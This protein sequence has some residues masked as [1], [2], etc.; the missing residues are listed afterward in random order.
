MTNLIFVAFTVACLIDFTYGQNC[1][2][3]QKAFYASKNMDRARTRY[4]DE[5]N[6]PDYDLYVTEDHPGFEVWAEGDVAYPFWDDFS[7]ARVLLT[8]T[9]IINHKMFFKREC[10]DLSAYTKCFHRSDVC[11]D[12]FCLCNECNAKSKY[13]TMGGTCNNI[14]NPKLGAQYSAYGRILPPDYH[15][16]IHSERRSAISSEELPSPRIISNILSQYISGAE[17]PDNQTSVLNVFGSIF[18]QLITHDVGSRIN[19]QRSVPFCF[20]QKYLRR[21]FEVNEG[22]FSFL[23]VCFLPDVAGPGIQCCSQYYTRRLSEDISHPAC[24]PIDIPTN[25]TFYGQFEANC[26]NFIS[27]QTTFSSKCEVGPA[28]QSNSVSAFLDLSIIYGDDLAT[29]KRL[30]SKKQ[31]RLITNAGN[32]LPEIPKCPQQP[33]YFLGDPRLVQTP[34]LAQWHSLFLRLHNLIAPQMSS[35]D[36]TAY[37]EGKRLTTALY[38]RLVYN[39]W[40]PIIL[41]EAESRDRQLSCDPSKENCGKYDPSVDPSTTNEFAHGAFRWLHAFIPSTI[42]LYGPNKELIMSRAF[43]DMNSSQVNILE[44]NYDDLI[45]GTF[46]DPINYGGWSPELRNRMMRD[47]KGM[48]TDLFS[49]DINR[50]RDHGIPSFPDLLSYCT[51]S[52]T[53]INSWTDLDQYFTPATLDTLQAVYSSHR[54]IDLLV[55]VLQER[56]STERSTLG[57]TGICIIGLQFRQLKYGDRFYYQWTDG[58]HPFTQPQLAEIEEFSMAKFL[59]S[60]TSL[61]SVPTNSFLTPSATNPMVSCASIPKFNFALFAK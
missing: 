57:P 60:V 19:V 46:Y 18:G 13:R 3:A 12:T 37:Q 22:L 23:F 33:C 40:L 51:N 39:E 34:M 17:Q 55:G 16:C 32:V 11:Y 5:L 47:S 10:E 8:T 44:T 15:D 6:P 28:Q 30:R 31:G 61:T 54:D 4:I 50:G 53:E 56:R 35:N 58:P 7:R 48:G 26:L 25:D 1:P 21:N 2:F 52:S 49:F 45:R 29:Q 42:N 27:S 43:S 41:G 20:R 14:G 9:E 59:C 38:Q 24:K 36:E